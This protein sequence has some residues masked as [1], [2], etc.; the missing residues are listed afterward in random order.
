M[1]PSPNRLSQFWQELKRRNVVR[2]MTVYAGAAFVIL[3]LVSMSEEPFGLPDWTFILAVVLL[4]MGFFIAV[5]LSWIYDIH[6]EGRIVKT[7][8]ADQITTEDKPRSINRWK[9]ASYISFIVIVGLIIINTIPRKGKKEVLEKSIA[10]LPFKN[11]S[12]DSEQEYMCNGLTDEIISHLFKIQS[13]EKVIPLNTILTYKDTE[14]QISEIAGELGV[15]YILDGTYKKLGDKV[16]VSVKLIDPIKDI[17]IWQNEYDKPFEEI[18]SIQIDIAQKIARELMTVITPG[19]LELIKKR[20]TEN[21]NSYNLYL[22]GR[23]SMY[24]HS[25]NGYQEAIRYFE[26]AIGMDPYY[27]KSYYWMAYSYRELSRVFQVPADQGYKTA[28]KILNNALDIDNTFGEAYAL[29]ASIR[30]ISDWDMKGPEDQFK[31]AMDVSPQSLD[32]YF[33]YAQYLLWSNR[34]DE[35]IVII[36]K[37]LEIEPFHVLSNQ[38]LGGIYFYGNRYDESI[39]QLKNMLRFTN[40]YVWAHVYLAHN[41]TMMGLPDEANYHADKAAKSENTFVLSAIAGN[42]A[43]SGRP[44]MAQKILD[45]LLQMPDNLTVDPCMIALIY[46]GLRMEDEA[47]MWLNKG[48][49]ARSGLMIYLKVYSSTFYKDLSLDPRYKELLKKVGFS[50][51]QY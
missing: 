8:S 46:A 43:R 35:A 14:K 10:V 30:F 27:I 15:N 24:S 9:I 44:D 6:P 13:F 3:E 20:P 1:A 28:K 37:A 16:R 33:L 2:V 36:N 17:Y 42:Y 29:L 45:K 26:Q 21:F 34:I 51:N 31:K 47:L 23:Y 48:L 11:F 18:L 19:E 22:K 5:I 38:W 41:Y 12:S 49:E 39:N 7:E 50:T 40:D 25:K 32:V 4:S